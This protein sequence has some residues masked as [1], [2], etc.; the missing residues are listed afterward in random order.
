METFQWDLNIQ[1]SQVDM[2]TFLI[3]HTCIKRLQKYL[4]LEAI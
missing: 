1:Y 2:C 3:L 4:T